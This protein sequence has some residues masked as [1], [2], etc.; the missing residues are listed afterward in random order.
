MNE[1]PPFARFEGGA[2]RLLD[3]PA[4]PARADLLVEPRDELIVEMNVNTHATDFSP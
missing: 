3:E 1:L 4:P 2:K